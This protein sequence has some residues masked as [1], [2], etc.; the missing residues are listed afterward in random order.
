MWKSYGVQC[1]IPQDSQIYNL[2]NIVKCYVRQIRGYADSDVYPENM[3][4]V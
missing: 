4:R 2:R 3:F 1:N